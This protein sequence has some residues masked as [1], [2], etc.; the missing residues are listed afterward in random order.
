MNSPY[1]EFANGHAQ[2]ALETSFDWLLQNVLVKLS[3]QDIAG[4]ATADLDRKIRIITDFMRVFVD[5]FGVLHKIN[6]SDADFN[7]VLAKMAETYKNSNMPYTTTVIPNN[8]PP[9]QQAGPSVAAKIIS[10]V[11]LPPPTVIAPQPMTVSQL[12][13]TYERDPFTG[14]VRKVQVY[15]PMPVHQPTYY[16]QP[17][18]VVYAAPSP[19]NGYHAP[20]G[21][22]LQYN[23]APGQYAPA[24]VTGPGYSQVYHVKNGSSSQQQPAPNPYAQQQPN[25]YAPQHQQYPPQQ[26]HVQQQP[27]RSSSTPSGYPGLSSSTAPV[28]PPP[29]RHH[30]VAPS[31]SSSSS[32][33]YTTLSTS[34]YQPSPSVLPPPGEEIPVHLPIDQWDAQKPAAYQPP[35]PQMIQPPVTGSASAPDLSAPSGLPAFAPMV[36]PFATTSPPPTAVPLEASA[37]AATHKDDDEDKNLCKICFERDLDCALLPCSHVTCYE[38]AT[39]LKLSKCPF[40]RQ[41]ISQVL[42]LYRA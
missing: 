10:P 31:S 25:P 3:A 36:N 22:T 11:P 34:N 39:S 35:A 17:T 41:E 37:P 2:E 21:R 18:G 14:Q 15:R 4:F 38:C 27:R 1:W 33:H 7:K 24:P 32:A 16:Q 12:V 42:K 28:Q 26:Q 23:A 20:N 9:S 6:L 5:I 40:C 30:Y 8:N 19:A 29:Q 13:T